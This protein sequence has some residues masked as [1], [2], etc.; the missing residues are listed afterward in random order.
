MGVGQ[1][2][3]R[4]ESVHAS[5]GARKVLD[6]VGFELGERELLGVLGPNGA[7]KS[8]LL[9]VAAGLHAPDAGRVAMGSSTL[10][11][12]A[13]REIARK[14]AFVPQRTEVTFAFTVLEVVLMGR[15]PHL[16]SMTIESETDRRIAETALREV[17]AWELRDRPFPALSG[18]ERQRVVIARALCQE[19]SILVLDEPAAFLD[20]RHQVELHELLRSGA[21]SG[22][23]SVVA[24]M[25]DLNLA[26]QVCDRVLLVCGG[27]V[28]GLGTVEEVLTYGRV[29][30]TFGTD[31]YVGVNELTGVRYFLPMVGRGR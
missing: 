25:H 24:A 7:G 18:G 1:P 29:R 11:G 16:G 21:R 6:G 23:F 9:R 26:A 12:L 14:L 5:Y 28:A 30:E 10:A 19:P 20:I 8:T 3:L 17:D 4:V 31:V 13:R 22:R 2:S 27:R 15:A